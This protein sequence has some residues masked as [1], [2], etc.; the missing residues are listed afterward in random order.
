MLVKAF[1]RAPLKD[2]GNASAGNFNVKLDTNGATAGGNI[3]L[4]PNSGI[5]VNDGNVYAASDNPSSNVVNSDIG[6]TKAVRP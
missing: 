5:T 6:G 1:I 4:A 3:V 2:T